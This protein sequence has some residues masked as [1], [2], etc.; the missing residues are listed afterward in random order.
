MATLLGN[1]IIPLIIQQRLNRSEPLC[2]EQKMTERE[3]RFL[4]GSLRP[5]LSLS[6]HYGKSAKMVARGKE[7]EEEEQ[8][9]RRHTELLRE[10]WHIGPQV[11]VVH[12]CLLH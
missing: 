4:V 12:F 11:H 1:R 8:N 5:S 10:E 9:A 6:L 3:D 7:E 2:L